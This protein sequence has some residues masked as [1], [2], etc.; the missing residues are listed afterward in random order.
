MIHS[1][2]QHSVQ[3]FV[4]RVAAIKFKMTFSFIQTFHVFYGLLW[5]RYDFLRFANHFYLHFIYVCK[6]SQ[7]FGSWVSII[8]LVY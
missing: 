7:L 5:K 2:K 8:K 4:Q 3:A 6:V 1:S